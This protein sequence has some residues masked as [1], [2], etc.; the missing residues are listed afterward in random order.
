MQFSKNYLVDDVIWN[1]FKAFAVSDSININMVG[2]KERTELSK[3]I[4]IL[5]AR[6]IWRNEGLYEVSNAEDITVK[7]ALEILKN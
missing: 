7:K 2:K 1:S 3:Q 5:T 6:Q 4:K